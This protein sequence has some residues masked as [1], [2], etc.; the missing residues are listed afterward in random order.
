MY[1][2]HSVTAGGF[3]KVRSSRDAWLDAILIGVHK[4]KPPEWWLDSQ[5]REEGRS[6]SQASIIWARHYKPGRKYLIWSQAPDD[7][8]RR[9]GYLEG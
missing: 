6:R 7:D 8:F 2:Y 9:L 5:E 1:V 3:G 4:P